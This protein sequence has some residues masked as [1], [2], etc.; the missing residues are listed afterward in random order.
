LPS[1]LWKRKKKKE[2][3]KMPFS[4]NA[5][6]AAIFIDFQANIFPLLF[7]SNDLKVSYTGDSDWMVLIVCFLL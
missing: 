6:V 1:Y 5:V 3:K 7:K 2:R 4:Q